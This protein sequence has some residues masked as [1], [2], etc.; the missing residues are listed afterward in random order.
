MI[1]NTILTF[2]VSAIFFSCQSQLPK[3]AKQKA[4]APE[5]KALDSIEQVAQNIEE[6]PPG[7]LMSSIEFNVKATAEDL[8]TFKDGIVGWIS[9]EHP[10]QQLSS[11]IGRDEVVL[12][13]KQISLIIDYPLN[14]PDTTKLLVTTAGFT[15]RQLIENISKRYHQIYQEEEASSKTKTVPID[16][17]TGLIN[18]NETDGKYGICCHDLSDLDLSTVEVYRTPA[19][20]III[21]LNVES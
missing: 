19:G 1:K 2:I 9:L 13:H 6:H 11:L 8:K 7:E 15:R 12:P 14:H 21:M 3:S 5:A 16:K 20:S 18:R 17:R 4:L 10:E